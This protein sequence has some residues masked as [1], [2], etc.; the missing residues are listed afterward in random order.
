MS[1][2]GDSILPRS[3][4]DVDLEVKK[5]IGLQILQDGRY[6]FEIEWQH[7]WEDGKIFK[8]RYPELVEEFLA[9]RDTSVKEEAL[10]IDKI[11]Q[12]SHSSGYN[13]MF[14]LGDD[15]NLYFKDQFTNV[16]RGSSSVELKEYVK[17]RMN[18]SSS[19]QNKRNI[20]SRK[21]VALKT[22]DA[23]FDNDDDDH[24]DN[25]DVYYDDD[26]DDDNDDDNVSSKAATEKMRSRCRG[27]IN[28][29][30]S[31]LQ[32][33][34]VDEHQDSHLR[35]TLPCGKQTKDSSSENV[36][37]VAEQ[38]QRGVVQYKATCTYQHLSSTGEYVGRPIWSCWA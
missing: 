10:S 17:R 3:S 11:E 38:N 16:D 25:D 4:R 27:G 20:Q 23:L 36:F 13:V 24:D 2:K 6:L 22:L 7:S 35:I 9:N 31:R 5:I 32:R 37:R 18:G 26:D 34:Q 1:G 30:I 29:I 28:A 33:N 21:R 12:I 19:S 15:Q 8:A 14:A